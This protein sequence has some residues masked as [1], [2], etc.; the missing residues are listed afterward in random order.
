KAV[1][2]MNEERYEDARAALRF[3]LDVWPRNASS[4]RL[5]AR[6]ERLAGRYLE[7]EEYLEKCEALEKEPTE[8]TQMERILL[9][10]ETGELDVVAPALWQLVEE[11]HPE[12]RA[13]LRTLAR[14]CLRL[15]RPVPAI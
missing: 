1:Q 2:A 5:A 4:L 10:A 3:C 14:A 6:I 9:R 11:N 13:I 8:P 15:S 12:S 7:A